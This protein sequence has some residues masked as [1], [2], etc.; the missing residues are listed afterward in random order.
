MSNGSVSV[1]QQPNI[2]VHTESSVD[3]HTD[4]TLVRGSICGPI[5]E[6]L[7]ESM[8]Q[9]VTQKWRYAFDTLKESNDYKFLSVA[10]S[11]M[12]TMV[13]TLIY[14]IDNLFKSMMKKE[15]AFSFSM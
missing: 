10:G 3:C 14:L 7:N 6:S 12:R 1:L 11:F 15:R 2:G 5:A 8:F 9:L 4:S 13:I